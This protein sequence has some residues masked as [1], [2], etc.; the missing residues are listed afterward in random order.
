MDVMLILIAVLVLGFLGGSIA[1][2]L[3]F[4]SETFRVE[5]DPKIAEIVQCLPGSNCGACGAG[6]CADFA[7]KV[8]SGKL[9]VNGCIA[10]GA[11]VAAAIA[12]ILGAAD[13]EF[14]P[15]RAVVHCGA[16]DSQRKKRAA[17]QGAKKCREMQLAGGGDLECVYGCLGLGDCFA[18]CP[19]D[20][21]Q[22]KE[23]LPRVELKK[24]TGCGK[25]VK[26]CPRN[27]ISLEV[28]AAGKPLYAVACSSRDKGAETR[29]ICSAGCMACRICEK[30]A[31]GVF[32]VEDN[33]AEIKDERATPE[34]NWDLCAEKCPPK[35]IVKLA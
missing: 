18:A 12:K 13:H 28:Y 16:V 32:V 20:S 19:F 10:G 29:R 5:T 23:G 14:I 1:F 31:P 24:C 22:M 8:A 27:I 15:K 4:A 21:M 26:A 25:C 30:H 3:A 17:Y 34:T 6:G 9:P 11:R 2:L 7:Q 35:C 33:L